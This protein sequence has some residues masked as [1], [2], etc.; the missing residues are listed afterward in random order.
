MSR[1]RRNSS[2]HRIWRKVPHEGKWLLGEWSRMLHHW[3][4]KDLQSKL[5]FKKN[6]DA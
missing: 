6:K 1:K 2:N 3:W 4:K 5:Q